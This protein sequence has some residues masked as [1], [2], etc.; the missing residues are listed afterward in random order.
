MVCTVRE[1]RMGGWLGC[2]CWEKQ[3]LLPSWVED[4][5]PQPLFTEGQPYREKMGVVYRDLF[6]SYSD[7]H[8][9]KTLLKIVH[10]ISSPVPK[11]KQ[12]KALQ[13]ICP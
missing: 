6:L 10:G 13:N 1:Q 5:A 7:F 11:I 2:L 12:L 3:C 8:I 9:Y 4:K